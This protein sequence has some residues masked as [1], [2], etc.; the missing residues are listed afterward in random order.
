MLITLQ[1]PRIY[2][3]HNKILENATDQDPR[4]YYLHNKILE[5]ATHQDPR[6]YY[7]HNKILENATDQDPRKY[8]L[9][10]KIQE[11]VT[12]QD[13]RNTTYTTKFWKMLLTWHDVWVSVFHWVA[14]CYRYGMFLAVLFLTIHKFL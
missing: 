14:S 7:L 6:K 4:K 9:H 11:N 12:D 3:S 10:N 2:Y 5:N 8:Y 1:D 13:P